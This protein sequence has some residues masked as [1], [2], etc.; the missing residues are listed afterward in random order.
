MPAPWCAEGAMPTRSARHLSREEFTTAKRLTDRS[1]ARAAGDVS[2]VAYN[3]LSGG[4]P[5]AGIK[6]E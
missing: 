3:S 2:P 1:H 5:V 6:P 4:D